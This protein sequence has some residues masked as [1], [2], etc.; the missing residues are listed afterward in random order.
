[1]RKAAVVGRWQSNPALG[2][3]FPQK[4][5]KFNNGKSGCLLEY[6]AAF[7]ANPRI[8]G[9]HECAQVTL[10]TAFGPTLL[11]S[12]KNGPGEARKEVLLTKA[13]TPLPAR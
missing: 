13:K 5:Q 2:E 9:A 12:A 11:F 1:M 3:S 8:S 10:A 4:V 6:P 7:H